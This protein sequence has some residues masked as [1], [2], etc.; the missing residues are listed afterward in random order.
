[1]THVDPAR[2]PPNRRRTYLLVF[3]ALAVMTAIEVFVAQTPGIP[4]VPVLLTM[5][6]AKALLVILYFMHLRYD[7]RWYSLI[8]FAPFLLVIP[9]LI[10]SQQ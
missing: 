5:S 7:S 4:V 3:V 1:M 6:L 8:F 9:L 2:T 10:V